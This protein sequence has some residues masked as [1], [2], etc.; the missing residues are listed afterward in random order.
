MK[1]VAGAMPGAVGECMPKNRLMAKTILAQGETTEWWE[2]YQEN[3]ARKGAGKGG[4][5]CLI[6]RRKEFG[7]GVKKAKAR[8]SNVSVKDL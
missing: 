7:Y 6:K 5:G 8:P 2:K 3:G 1:V 4:P